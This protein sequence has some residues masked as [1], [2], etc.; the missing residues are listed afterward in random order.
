MAA[1]LLTVHGKTM[2][3]ADGDR[4][5]AI[6][7]YN[8]GAATADRSGD[9][10]ARVWARGRA[11]LALAY[12]GAE[13]PVAQRF[14][15]D[16]LAISDRPSGGQLNALLALAHIHGIRG[17]AASA[18]TVLDD[19][20]RVFEA[21]APHD[22]IS[23]FAIPEWRFAIHES[24]LFSR[25]GYEYG[26]M[27]AQA[28]VERERPR[29]LTRF[30]THVELHRGLMMAKAG[31]TASGVAYA[32]AALAELPPHKHS[33][34]LRLMMDEIEATQQPWEHRQAV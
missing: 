22:E 23:D 30:A 13:L 25:L 15:D 27:E 5:S 10:D 21:T 9:V 11:A 33:L 16:A 14:A 24:M 28:V 17:D 3:S 8:L 29:R 26:A 31:D 6:R 18:V 12:E 7:W 32:R 19:A 4:T 20:R 2:P 34:S 1:R